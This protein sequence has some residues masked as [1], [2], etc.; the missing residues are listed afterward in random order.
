MFCIYLK[1]KLGSCMLPYVR[2]VEFQ[3]SLHSS[4]LK[5]WM[6]N[7]KGIKLTL[8]WKQTSPLCHWIKLNLWP[9]SRSYQ[10][11]LLFSS[12]HL[13]VLRSERVG[14]LELPALS[15]AFLDRHSQVLRGV[16]LPALGSLVQDRVSWALGIPAQLSLSYKDMFIRY[17]DAVPELETALEP[18]WQLGP[19]HI[20]RAS[21]PCLR[22]CVIQS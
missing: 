10:L 9:W 7:L 13:L 8:G 17:S 4:C 1:N 11:V 3:S 5:K 2:N 19:Q 6:K 18:V 22:R 20:T 16:I 21:F 15:S 12:K 14:R